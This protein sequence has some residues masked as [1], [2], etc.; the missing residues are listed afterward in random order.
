[1]LL[2]LNRSL[3]PRVFIGL[4]NQAVIRA[5]YDFSPK[6]GHYILDHL[7]T[8]AKKLQER[9]D[10]LGDT[11]DIDVHWVPGH[12]GYDENEEV[13]EEAKK[14]AKGRSSDNGL[15]P[16]FLRTRLPISISAARQS[17]LATLSKKWT[18]EWKK[19]PRFHKHLR[20]I[21][22]SLPSKS[23]MKLVSPLPRN[24][25]SLLIQ[26]RTGH[27]PLQA[28]LHRIHR[29]DSPNC[30][31]CEDR[32]ETVRHFLIECPHYRVARTRL[33]NTLRR[34]AFSL[35]HLLS[36]QRAVKPLMRYVI[37]THRF[38]NAPFGSIVVDRA[39]RDRA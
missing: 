1:M 37:A 4:D 34:N 24:Q 36:T 30:P 32:P 10:R 6:P 28:H 39:G 16:A 27:A 31:H 13:D 26:L 21:D 29:A 11:L 8:M 5:L 7:H 9:H 23:F 18:R 33:S 2:S 17:F 15:L 14:A 22:D 25:A 19:S 12:V 38:D 3:S 35:P 20:F